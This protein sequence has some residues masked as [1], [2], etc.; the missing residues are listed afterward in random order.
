[1]RH[2][3]PCQRAV[4]SVEKDT[5]DIENALRPCRINDDDDGYV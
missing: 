5:D 3:A 2:D 4:E 1:M